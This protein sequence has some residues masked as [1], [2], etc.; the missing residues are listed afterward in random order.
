M[1]VAQVLLATSV[2]LV[3]CSSGISVAADGGTKV[4]TSTTATTGPDSLAATVLADEG[5]DNNDIFAYKMP[6]KYNNTTGTMVITIDKSSLKKVSGDTPPSDLS[7]IYDF[8]KL[9][10]NAQGS[11][12]EERG[13]FSFAA[14]HFAQYKLTQKAVSWL[15]GV[16]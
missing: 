2:V 4:K 13:L 1:R 3:A 11:G 15:K 6:F 16:F 8:S 5:N 9:E 7:Q 12:D 10:K 14:T